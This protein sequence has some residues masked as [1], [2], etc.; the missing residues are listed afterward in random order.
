[1]GRFI[2]QCS[3]NFGEDRVQGQLWK[4]ALQSFLADN[5][6]RVDD[7]EGLALYL[8]ADFPAFTF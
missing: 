8:A 7:K 5:D 4:R 6:A 1:L 3:W 2:I